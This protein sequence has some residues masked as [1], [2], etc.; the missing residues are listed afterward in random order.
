[1]G[2]EADIMAARAIRPGVIDEMTRHGIK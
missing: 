2:S 1:V